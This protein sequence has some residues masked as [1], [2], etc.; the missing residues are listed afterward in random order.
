M[1]SINLNNIAIL[2]NHGVDYCCI[3]NGISKCEAIYLLENADLSKKSDHYETW[4][5]IITYKRWKKNKTGKCKFHYHKDQILLECVD[6]GKIFLSTKVSS[7]G[8]KGKKI[9]NTLLVI[10]MIMKLDYCI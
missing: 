10:K 4:I 9:I 1:V 8:K 5:F 3:I 2:N 7:R 6:T